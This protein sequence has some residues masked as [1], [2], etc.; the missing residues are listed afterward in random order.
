MSWGPAKTGSCGPAKTGRALST[1]C[2]AK[3]RVVAEEAV[4]AVTRVRQL[5]AVQR[6]HMLELAACAGKHAFGEKKGGKKHAPPHMTW[7]WRQ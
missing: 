5:R 7:T 1:C 4:A 2:E 3:V 6:E